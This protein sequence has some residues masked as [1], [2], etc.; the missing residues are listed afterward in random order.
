MER[1]AYFEIFA[2]RGGAGKRGGYR[3]NRAFTYVYLTRIC[4]PRKIWGNR[5]KKQSFIL[6]I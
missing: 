4:C 1:G 3:L 5:T 2:Q 6:V